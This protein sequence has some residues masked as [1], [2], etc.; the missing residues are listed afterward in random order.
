MSP[1]NEI[2]DVAYTPLVTRLSNYARASKQDLARLDTVPFQQRKCEPGDI[3]VGRGDSITDVIFMISGW[4]ARVRYTKGGRR[5][6]IHI[7]LPGDLLTREVFVIR[8]SDHELISLTNTVIRFVEQK[9]LV[10]LF[11]EAPDLS[12]ALWWAA[13]QEEGIL[14]EH[15]V[16]LGRRSSYERT[17]HL[18]LELH[19]R[20]VLIRQATESVFVLPITQAEI[21]DLLGLSTIHVNRTLVKLRSEGL[22]KQNKRIIQILDP[23][24]MADICDF[25]LAHLHLDGEDVDRLMED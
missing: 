2:T 16:R 12:T 19:R 1:Q 23:E 15:I 5:Q 14:R 17:C 8:R 6:I 9:D 4:A 22:I 21:A 10:D 13:E 25:D 18:L 3:I 7:L 24:A 11:R 20:L